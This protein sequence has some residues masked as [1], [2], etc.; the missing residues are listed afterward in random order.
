MEEI[1]NQKKDD[2]KRIDNSVLIVR[3]YNWDS[4]ILVAK[5]FIIN[6]PSRRTEDVRA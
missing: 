2:Q 1:R 5:F 4:C 3:Q 6:L